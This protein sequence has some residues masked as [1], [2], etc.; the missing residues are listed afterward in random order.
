M[1]LVEI[2]KYYRRKYITNEV[3]KSI[4]G[5]EKPKK[6][7]GFK[8]FIKFNTDNRRMITCIEKIG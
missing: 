2:I 8:N 1:Q 6:T 3:K 7:A 4:S 5:R